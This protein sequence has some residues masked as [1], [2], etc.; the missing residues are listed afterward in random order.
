MRKL[1]FYNPYIQTLC[2][3]IGILGVLNTSFFVSLTK[4]PVIY[5]QLFFTL[6]I[7]LFLVRKTAASDTGMMGKYRVLAEDIMSESISF[8]LLGFA[9]NFIIN[10]LCIIP[11]A[12]K[13]MLTTG[14]SSLQWQN[15]FET[16]IWITLPLNMIF[17]IAVG[18]WSFRVFK[19]I[20]ISKV[21]YY[22]F[23]AF[24][25]FAGIMDIRNNVNSHFPSIF[26]FCIPFLIM[27]A[28][29]ICLLFGELIKRHLG[30]HVSLR[31]CSVANGIDDTKQ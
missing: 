6:F 14:N 8:L 30:K 28:I 19:K 27:L 23:A 5:W 1:K 9:W 18:F 20:G 17:I 15:T 24:Y 13:P 21:S 10:L 29:G 7:L 22:S 3:I 16:L 11:L 26:L 31:T 25:S 2:L 4:I 12:S